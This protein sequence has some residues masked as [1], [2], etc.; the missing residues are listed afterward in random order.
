MIDPKATKSFSRA[1]SRLASTLS[2]PVTFGPKASRHAWPSS[3]SMS[4]GVF[5][6]APWITAVIDPN[7]ACASATA[8]RTALGSVTSATK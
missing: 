5:V 4:F 3:E 2:A 1:R 7:V 8:L 6:P